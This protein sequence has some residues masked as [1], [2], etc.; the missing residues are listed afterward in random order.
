MLILIIARIYCDWMRLIIIRMNGYGVEEHLGDKK[1]CIWDS[2]IEGWDTKHYADLIG[3]AFTIPYIFTL[4]LVAAPAADFMNRRLVIACAFAMEIIVFF[5]ATLMHKVITMN[6]I[7][8][9]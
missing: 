4:M 7:R 6:N 9:Y 5:G 3:S 2:D 1:Y 8:I